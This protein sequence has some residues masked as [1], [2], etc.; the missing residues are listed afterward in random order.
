V[1]EPHIG[2][3][4]GQNMTS[5]TLEEGIAGVT[6]CGP[7]RGID[8]GGGVS[9]EGRCE[10]VTNCKRCPFGGVRGGPQNSD[11][12]GGVGGGGG[13]GQARR[14]VGERRNP[15]GSCDKGKL[16]SQGPKNK[17]PPWKREHSSK[18]RGFKK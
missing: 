5:M 4:T 8:N 16:G 15:S 17:T 12:R 10:K 6:S 11:G 3:H 2:R 1:D 9:G 18:Y 14:T 7:A 13:G